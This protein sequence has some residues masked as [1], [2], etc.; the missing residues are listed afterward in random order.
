M[1]LPICC[2]ANMSCIR[3]A[4]SWSQILHLTCGFLF[5]MFWQPLGQCYANLKRC[6]FLKENWVSAIWTSWAALEGLSRSQRQQPWRPH[7]LSSSRAPWTQGLRCLFKHSVFLSPLPSRVSQG[8]NQAWQCLAVGSR[9]VRE[10]PAAGTRRWCA[11]VPQSVCTAMHTVW[12]YQSTL[13]GG[14]FLLPQDL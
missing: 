11:R 6:P 3:Q 7:S 5:F 10:A 9:Q 4:C 8:W 1:H 14:G 2:V 13:L 12:V